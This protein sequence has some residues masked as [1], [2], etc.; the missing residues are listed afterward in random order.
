MLQTRT[1]DRNWVKMIVKMRNEGFAC[2]PSGGLKSP[3][4]NGFLHFVIFMSLFLGTTV[5]ADEWVQ[6][7]VTRDTWLSGVGEEANGSNG[8]SPRLKL[9][10]IQ[11]LSIIDYE[12][13]KLIG[14]E[15]LDAYLFLKV[16]GDEPI[17]RVTV[18]TITADWVEGDATGYQIVDG[19]STFLHRLHSAERWPGPDVT[20]V[21]IGNGGSFYASKD[22]MA[23]KAAIVPP[24]PFPTRGDG[25]V[26]IAVPE[27]ILRARSAGL[28]FGIVLMDDTGSTW[29]RSGET[30]EYKLFPNRYVYSRDS[31]SQSAPYLVVRLGARVPHSSEAASIDPPS[32][33]RWRSADLQ[34]PWRRLQWRVPLKDLDDLLG[35]RITI[36]GETIPAHEIPCWSQHRDGVFTMNLESRLASRRIE[37]PARLAI[38][39]IDRLGRTT[40]ST[41]VEVDSVSPEIV[42]WRPFDRRQED[43][44]VSQRAD[45]TRC[46]SAGD[47]R[48]AILDPLD[49]WLPTS[50]RIV[51]AQSETYLAQNHL[52]NASTRQI[53][54]HAPRG[55]WVGFQ[56]ASERPVDGIACRA[57]W[58]D[59]LG[60][61]PG[62]RMECSRY[63][64]VSGPSEPI[65]DPL[66][67][68]VEG[69]NRMAWRLERE[70]SSS[71]PGQS[72]LVESYIPK[73]TPAGTYQGKLVLENS[74]SRTELD[75]S[76]RVHDV[77]IPERLSFLP[78]MNSYDLPDNDID[79]YRLGNR[80]RVVVNRLP[81]YQNGRLATD[82]CP[83]WRD[84]RMDW[85]SYDAHYG[86]L[87]SGRA[88]ADLPRG[89]I[90]IEC[91]YLP[92]HENW[93]SPMEGNYNGGYWADRA[94][95]A[96]YRQAFVSAVEQCADHFH[97]KG[98]HDTRFHVYLNNKVDFKQR[99][100]SRGSS[101]WLLDEPANFQDYWALNYF[102]RAAN[103]GLL[104]AKGTDPNHAAK[105][106]FRA[107]ISRPQWQRD[108]LDGLAEYY[109]IS[110]SSF[111][112]YLPLVLERKFRDGQ[113]VVVYGSSNPIG[114][115]N[116]M[117]VAWC[118]DAWC[119]GADGIVPWQTIGNADSWK[120]ADELS[121]FYPHPTDPRQGPAP[122]IRLKAYCYGQQDAELLAQL[123]AK[124]GVSRY[125][126]GDWLLP[127]LGL[128]ANLR[129]E[130]EFNEPAAWNDYSG[131]D[132]STM[133]QFRLAWMEALESVENRETYRP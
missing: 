12:F 39:A 49:L 6:L 57:E 9:K 126:F 100:W 44:P 104:L 52:W 7:A 95:P 73:Q 47:S 30:F 48:W 28:S 3:L 29:T 11:E 45:W 124:A 56:V 111:Q 84:G 93:P 40:V 13:E 25:W 54:L 91:F 20:S 117:A 31:H 72:W 46:L 97:R 66:I 89:E 42:R 65:P 24:A 128:R 68:V 78:E 22:A 15:I 114:K 86:D 94:F 53:T 51:P 38:A 62:L 36:D 129:A 130:G 87:F 35:F 99:G 58:E 115:S 80:H 98:W 107:D 109:V 61:V 75:I 1:L 64:Y 60:R 133:H 119:R 18:S 90:P 103:E 70:N 17:E 50:Q 21:C 110:F 102:A 8:G 79:Y 105:V 108:T 113:T 33:L 92:M 5:R 85:E 127:Q 23:S 88:F 32:E 4:L 37:S 63:G 41:R 69:S 112:E 26:Q 27:K 81:Y 14:R 2:G 34:S 77:A 19:V 122:S 55:A 16:A 82:R 10:S 123:A 101:P 59:A 96:S 132:A 116:T 83:E 118:W 120:K 125:T 121:L 67:P 131:V 74:A 71:G 43:R 76:L 106:L